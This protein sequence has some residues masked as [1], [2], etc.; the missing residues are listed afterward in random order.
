MEGMIQGAGLFFRIFA[1][2]SAAFALADGSGAFLMVNQ[3]CDHIIKSLALPHARSLERLLCNM[4]PYTDFLK[5]TEAERRLSLPL[6]DGNNQ[7]RRLE[8]TLWRINEDPAAQPAERGPFMGI[9]LRDQTGEWMEE[10]RLE[11]DVHQ[12]EQAVEA[13]SIFLA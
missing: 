10:R 7:D 4:P 13:K 8:V 3:E 2:S 12:A 9:S 1:E 11:E 6:R 5:T